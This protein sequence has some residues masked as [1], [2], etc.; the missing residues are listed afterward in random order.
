MPDIP[1]RNL[2][3]RWAEEDANMTDAERE[4]EDRLWDDLE[5]SL[6]EARVGVRMREL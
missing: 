5:K 2:F 4:A 6:R 3:A 1:T